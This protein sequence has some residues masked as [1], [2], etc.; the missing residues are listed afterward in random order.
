[1]TR[2]ELANQKDIQNDFDEV[3]NGLEGSLFCRKCSSYAEFFVRFHFDMLCE[4]EGHHVI[5][6]TAIDFETDASLVVT[7]ADFY[8]VLVCEYF[9]AAIVNNL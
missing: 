2:T 1:M 4:L 8:Q 6:P 3:I 9:I 7:T 5:I